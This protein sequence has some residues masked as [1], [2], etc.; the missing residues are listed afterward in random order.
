MQLT[1]HRTNRT[2]LVFFIVAL[3]LIALVALAP[4]PVDAAQIVQSEEPHLTCPAGYNVLLESE[5]L[6]AVITDRRAP[7]RIDTA[8]ALPQNMTSV[9]MTVWTSMGHPDLG[10]QMGDNNDD[11]RYPCDQPQ[12]NEEMFIDAFGGTVF[13]PDHGN[14]QW[15]LFGSIDYGYQSAG[16]YGVTFRHSNNS[17]NRTAESVVYKAIVCGQPASPEWDKSSLEFRG[18]TN[19]SNDTVSAL[20]CNGGSDMTFQST[21][22]LY[23]A[24]RGNAKRGSVIASGVF[25]PLASGECTTLSASTMGLGG[26]FKFRATQHPLHPGRGELWS[27]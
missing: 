15:G 17:I 22:E 7:W 3:A 13:V 11:G 21:W 2:I 8:V 20:V 25:G 19:V 9:F 4:T 16:T 24:N 12:L 1:L 10:C 27:D 23:Q 6:L 14:D 18:R 5:A 26:N